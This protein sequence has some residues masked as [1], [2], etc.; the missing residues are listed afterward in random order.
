MQQLSYWKHPD[1]GSSDSMRMKQ[2]WCKP[3]APASAA[4]TSNDHKCTLGT[5]RQTMHL[6]QEQS[7]HATS[8]NVRIAGQISISSNANGNLA[9]IETIE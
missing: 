7:K 4:V 6:M 8:A 2:Q 1:Q 5:F 3:S 9:F